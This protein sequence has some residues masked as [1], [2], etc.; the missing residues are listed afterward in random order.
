MRAA[1]VAGI[2]RASRK[3]WWDVGVACAY[4]WTA[5]PNADA[6]RV[7]G[8]DLGEPAWNPSAQYIICPCCG[9]ESGVDDLDERQARRYLVFWV[10]AGGRW[11]AREQ[12]PAGWSLASHLDRVGLSVS[13]AELRDV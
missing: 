3:S 9:A 7:C 8:W 11:F 10:A 2:C 6:C 1:K 4:G 12:R 5:A 13:R